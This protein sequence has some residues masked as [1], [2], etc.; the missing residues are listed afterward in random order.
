MESTDG[1]CFSRGMAFY[2]LHAFYWPKFMTLGQLPTF[3]VMFKEII[4]QFKQPALIEVLYKV[5][6]RLG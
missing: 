2:I 1:G 5:D 6:A 4:Y 3:K